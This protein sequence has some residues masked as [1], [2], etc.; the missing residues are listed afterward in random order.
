[1]V[2]SVWPE[3]VELMESKAAAIFAPGNPEKFHTV[4]LSYTQ[5]QPLFES[6]FGIQFEY[7]KHY[8]TCTAEKL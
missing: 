5:R 2:Y 6:A 8:Y 4:S 1:M 7:S 3:V